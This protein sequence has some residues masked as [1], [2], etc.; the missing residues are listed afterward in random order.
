MKPRHQ[1]YLDEPNQ[2]ELDRL[3]AE[4]GAT[5]SAIVNAAL[6]SYFAHRGASE[7]ERTFRIRLERMSEFLER[8]ERNQ[9]IALE[10]FALFVHYELGITPQLPPAEQAAAQAVGRD[11][12]QHF[13]EQVSRRMAGDRRIADEVIARAVQTGQPDEPQRMAAE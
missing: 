2:E 1:F 8:L 7:L 5:R 4:R 13:I 11:R 12:F 9:H 3:A 6:K 10:S